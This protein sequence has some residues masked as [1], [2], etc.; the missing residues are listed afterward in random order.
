MLKAETVK[1]EI[2]D[3]VRR[4]NRPVTVTE[5]AT[6]LYGLKLKTDPNYKFQKAE[7]LLKKHYL[8]PGQYYTENIYDSEADTVYT[9]TY[10]YF[11]ALF[12]PGPLLRPTENNSDYLIC[13]APNKYIIA[14][15]HR[16]NPTFAQLQSFKDRQKSVK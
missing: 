15:D 16:L 6:V 10:P 7:N 9:V 12:Q 8:K 13:C 4:Q 5:L 14:H 11:H 2:L 1:S 3:F